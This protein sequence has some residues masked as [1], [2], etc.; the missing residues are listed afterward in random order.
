MTNLL[1]EEK[2]LTRANRHVLKPDSGEHVFR[3]CV[4]EGLK[5]LEL[6]LGTSIESCFLH[7]TFSE[8]EWHEPLFN[9]ALFFSTKFER[10]RFHGGSFTGCTFVACEFVDCRFERNAHK[11]PCTFDDVRWYGC[12]KT[13]S[14]G[15]EGQF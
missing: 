3:Y 8:C 1:I 6:Q 11:S 9:E 2:H 15:L 12:L 10:C 13:G 14:P 4:F 7:C 5:D